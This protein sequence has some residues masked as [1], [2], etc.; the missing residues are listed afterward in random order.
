MPVA[1]ID[2]YVCCFPCNPWPIKGKRLGFKAGDGTVIWESI[3]TI[4][5]L[6]PALIF[7][8]NV[9]NIQKTHSDTS[10]D[11]DE[12]HIT[13]ADLEVICDYMQ[14]ELPV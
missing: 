7:M 3:E 12:P 1:R 14:V 5:H 8:E 4:K 9:L 2:I 6:N 11:S 13:Q 10:G